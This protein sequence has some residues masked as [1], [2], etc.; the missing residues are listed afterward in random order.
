MIADTAITDP[1]GSLRSCEYEPKIV[2]VRERSLIE[3]RGHVDHAHEVV[4]KAAKM[5]EGQSALSELLD[6]HRWSRKLA[7]DEKCAEFAYAFLDNG[8]PRL[9]SIAK[10]KLSYVGALHLG[11]TACILQ[12]SKIGA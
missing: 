7:G 9:C 3:F 4:E 5:S 12:I 8:L 1:T 10:G 6:G 2:P 11:S